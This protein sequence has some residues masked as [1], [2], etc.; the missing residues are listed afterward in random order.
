MKF[1]HLHVHSHYSLLDGLAK[2]DKLL[3]R[4]KELGMNSV[5]LTDHGVMYGA[6]EFYKKAKARGIKPII[7]IEL[8]IAPNGMMNKRPKIDDK[9]YHIILL[10][11]N[12]TGYKNIIKLATL[13]HLEGFYY[14]PRIDKETLK[15]YSEGLIGTSACVSGEISRLAIAGKF[16]EAEKAAL[17]YESIFGK[18][19]FYLEIGFHPSVPE[20]KTANEALIKI[21][22]KNDIGI[23]ATNDIHYLKKEDAEAQDALMAI[24]TKSLI[25]D[26]NRLTMKNDDFSMK[27]P[28]EMA[29]NFKDIPEALENTQK[30]ADMC[31]LEIELGKT[32]LPHFEVP[33]GKTTDEYLKQLCAEGIKIKYGNT[34]DIIDKRL[35]YELSV[36]KQTGFASYILIVR[37][38]VHWAKNNNI[39]V[40]PGRGSAA[41]SIVSYLLNITT[42]D[43][44]KY[45]L[46]FERFL[47]PERISMPDIDLD[48]AD[49]RRDEVIEYVSKK[50]GKDHVAQIITFGTMAARAAVR[51]TGRVL[52]YPYAFCDQT[53][54][55]IPMFASLEEALN[56]VPE[57]KQAY[58][59]NPDT[60]KLIDSAKKLE[61]VARH[62]STHACGVVITKEKL[63]NYTPLQ[64]A[65]QNEKSIITQYEMHAI[66]DLGLLKMDFLG[67]KNLTIIETAI[68]IIQNTKNE[69]IDFN[70]IPLD[71]QKTFELFQKG[72]T[73]GIFQYESGGMKRNLRALKPTVFE[74]LIAMNA[75]Y[76]PGP[77][78]HIPEYIDA[79]HG[80]KKISY[81]HPKMEP[82]LKNTYGVIVYQEQVLEIVKQLAGFSYGEADVLRKAV[83]KKIK[84][85]LE[86]QRTKLIEKLTKNGIDNAMT[87]K[88][89]NF[90]EPFARYG[91]NKSHSACYATIGY[92]TAYLKTHYPTEFMA[93]LMNAEQNDI[94]RIAE[95]IKEC[96][97]M[98]IEVLPPN[99]NESFSNFTVVSPKQI[100]FGLAAVKNVGKNVVAAIVAERKKSGKYNKLEEFITRVQSK[101]LNKKSLE[102]LI[103]CG[104]TEELG[105]RKKLLENIEDILKFAR[106]LQKSKEQ[107]Q[108]SLFE[109]EQNQNILPPMRLKES[110]AATK[111]ERLQ[112]EKELLGLYISE[113][114]LKE[115]KN[116]LDTLDSIKGIRSKTEGN[117]ICG[118]I[119]SKIKKILT[120]QNQTMLFVEMEDLTGQIEIIVFPRALEA[121]PLI[122]QNDKLIV[123]E[124]AMNNKDGVP[125][126]I[127]AKTHFLEEYLKKIPQKPVIKHICIDLPKN[128]GDRLM[129]DLQK[130]FAEFPTGPTQISISV[131]NGELKPNT[132][133]TP[134]K[135]K[136]DE[137][138]V[139]KLKQ[140]GLNKIQ[141][142]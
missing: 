81:L 61:G 72:N 83:G 4:V 96:N 119:I 33:D 47:N 8:Y 55:M 139:I 140:L 27:S 141:I 38:F 108:F 111:N 54:K 115:F 32:Q 100:R 19:N 98:S 39:I 106:D 99:I 12:N 64:R 21:G 1:T 28:E 9:R 127:A 11:K 2:I 42:I 136:Y 30:I 124:G 104:A 132:I 62:A 133:E 57:L 44:L 131:A 53:S 90:I 73:T 60:K 88:I 95:I 23:I 78:D 76:R 118:G 87:G 74:D 135:I 128:F 67:L 68:K 63:E 105:E 125:K 97:D 91:F 17:E 66:E 15:K 29:E 110:L 18:G 37:D 84:S 46:L 13:A 34:T 49:T 5:A 22:K 10:A 129:Q 93:A 113:H 25:S 70:T 123:V 120:R 138:I 7:G 82:I 59:S 126:I 94:E 31:N 142:I 102:S 16:D 48:F 14:K 35:E 65:P 80:L 20:Q 121:N 6:I 137:S 43:P 77:M 58:N 3:D 112:W 45:N 85:L 117:V 36:I 51:D 107:G 52:G 69:I 134:Y 86:E 75:L 24:Q 114:P 122:W 92:Q 71:D 109:N 89:W 130:I 116:Q 101:D 50:Y 40:G 79:K 56:N 103:K 26:T 41:G